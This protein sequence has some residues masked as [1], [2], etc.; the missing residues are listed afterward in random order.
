MEKGGASSYARV[1]LTSWQM[2]IP[3]QRVYMKY[4]LMTILALKT[5]SPT[6]RMV[7]RVKIHELRFQIVTT[8]FLI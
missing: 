1:I 3:S 4:V 7:C 8:V 2:F 5:Y 6:W